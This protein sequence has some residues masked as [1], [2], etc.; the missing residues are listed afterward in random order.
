VSVPLAWDE[1][2]PRLRSDHYTVRNLGRRLA[3]RRADPW[4]AYW[5]TRQK[6]SAKAFAAVAR[7]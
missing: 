2:G 5:T 7:L 3:A 1:L 4:K 6:I